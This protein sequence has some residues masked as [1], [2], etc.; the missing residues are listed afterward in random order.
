MGGTR[1]KTATEGG[2]IIEDE[3]VPIPQ[4]AALNF[5][6]DG[7][8]ASDGSGKT[9]V[10][11]PAGA[12]GG[13]QSVIPIDIAVGNKN[14]WHYDA[15]YYKDITEL[16]KHNYQLVGVAT[17]TFSAGGGLLTMNTGGAA[18]GILSQVNTLQK[19]KIPNP[20]LK[21]DL[22]WR[23]TCTNRVIGS[24][25]R[26]T[27]VGWITDPANGATT[28]GVAL[29]AMLDSICF[30]VN[31]ND[32]G[33]G[34][35]WIAM[36]QVGTS[37]TLTDSGVSSS[38]QEALELRSIDGGIEFYINNILVATHTT[39]IPLG[40]SLPFRMGALRANNG[41]VKLD[42]RGITVSSSEF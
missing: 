17:P 37:R 7:V 25:N 14:H 30:I 5:V 12:G 42:V 23:A 34:N 15:F 20:L 41:P 9:N 26:F 21:D 19:W 38:L 28:S 35:N 8:V 33:F 31:D 6:G 4:K 36:T 24:Q 13:P 32:S 3:G 10:T 18:P 1:L 40:A 27:Y 16:F 39:N 11:I 2:H 22:F 29:N